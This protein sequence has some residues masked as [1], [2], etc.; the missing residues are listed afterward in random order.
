MAVQ[1]SDEERMLLELVREL[2]AEK[3]A[4]RAAAG[5]AAP[6]SPA[7]QRSVLRWPSN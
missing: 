1:L 3:V 7:T 2:V 4:P 5:D 6:A